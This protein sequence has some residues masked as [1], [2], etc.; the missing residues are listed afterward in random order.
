MLFEQRM[1]GPLQIPNTLPMDDAD[2]QNALL[3]A[4]L[5]ISQ[6]HFFDLSGPKRVQVHHAINRQR[7]RLVLKL[8][9]H[10]HKMRLLP[11]ISQDTC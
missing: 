9:S 3:L 2:L 6:H 4:R 7:Y 11:K 10:D 1:N 8:L 5:Q